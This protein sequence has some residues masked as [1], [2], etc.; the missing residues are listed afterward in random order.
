VITPFLFTCTK[1]S[2]DQSNVDWAARSSQQVTIHS[3]L[4]TPVEWTL[5]FLP[6]CFCH[7]P[8]LLRR[9]SVISCLSGVHHSIFGE[10][11]KP[12]N[13]TINMM[14]EGTGGKKEE[15]GGRNATGDGKVCPKD[16]ATGINPGAVECGRE[17]FYFLSEQTISL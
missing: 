17:Y 16:G 7:S 6:P 9:S 14:K 2:K 13:S 10:N 5:L 11:R 1:G 4:G 12:W 3:I 8:T 15:D